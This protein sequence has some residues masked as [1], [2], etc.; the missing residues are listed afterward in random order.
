[1]AGEDD[2]PGLTEDDISLDEPEDD[3]PVDE[4]DDPPEDDVDAAGEDGADEPRQTRRPNRAEARI[5]ALRREREEDRKRYDREIED[6]RQRMNQPQGRQDSPEEIEARL[7]LMSPEERTDYR[8]RQAEERHSRRQAESDF[9]N[10]DML[11]RM[12]FDNKTERDP[13]YKRHATEVETRLQ[14]LRRQGQ[15]APREAL[16]K[17]IVGEKA[18]AARN[19]GNGKQ[20]KRAEAAVRRQVSPPLNG[21]GDIRAERGQTNSLARRLENVKL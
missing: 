21:R 18:L 4:G 3:I 1:M 15:N 10:A 11:D 19:A 12:Q 8:L 9:R 2:D 13:V 17:Y 5:Q 7:A 20:K 6:L 14:E 16:L